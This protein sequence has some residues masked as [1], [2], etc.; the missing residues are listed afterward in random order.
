[1]PFFRTVEAT[2]TSRDGWCL[3]TFFLS[4]G[5]PSRLDHAWSLLAKQCLDSKTESSTAEESEGSDEADKK[6]TFVNKLV[7]EREASHNPLHGI[8]YLKPT[9]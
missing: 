2:S 9:A 5:A 8:C 6:N 1:M 3:R 7:S 4:P